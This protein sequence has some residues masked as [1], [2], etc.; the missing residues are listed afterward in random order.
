MHRTKCLA[1]L[2]PLVF[3]LL[4]DPPARGSSRHD[5][6]GQWQFHTDASRQGE[7]QGW[8]RQ[9]PAGAET[10]RV[11][12]TWNVGKYEDYEGTAWYFRSFTVPGELLGRHFE[13]NFAATFYH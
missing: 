11:P 5:L 6:N 8:P 1:A 12:H 10:V 13:L 9:A 7:G 3:C 2:A 4:F